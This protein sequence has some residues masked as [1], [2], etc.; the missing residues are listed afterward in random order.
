MFNMKDLGLMHYYLGLEVWQ[1][2]SEVFLGQGK[3]VIKILKNFGMT[4][5]KSMATPTGTNLKKLRGSASS[6]VDP[7]IYRRLIGMYS[8]RDIDIDWAG[9]VEDRKCTSRVCFSLGSTMISWM[10]KRQR[11][12]SLSSA[13]AEYITTNE[14]CSEVVWLQNL[15]ARL[16]GQELEPTMIH[17]DN[18]SCV[19]LSKNPVFHDKSKHIEVKYHYIRDMV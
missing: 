5:F 17:C 10:S 6:L 13:K 9:S 7:S 3:Y 2:P 4:D 16:F 15:F 8:F 14:A 1:K 12:I 11:S 18:Q 19:K